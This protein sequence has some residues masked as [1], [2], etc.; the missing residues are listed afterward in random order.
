MAYCRRLRLEKSRQLLRASSL[1]LT[2]IALATGFAG[3]SHFSSSFRA[4]FGTS[5]RSL[6]GRA[7]PAPADKNAVAFAPP[8]IITGTG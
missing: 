6:R 2:Q 3:S 5:P 4:A 1:N 7:G 8:P